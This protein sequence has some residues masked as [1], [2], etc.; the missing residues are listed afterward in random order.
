MLSAQRRRICCSLPSSATVDNSSRPR[1]FVLRGLLLC[2]FPS[3][4]C[5]SGVH[6]SSG[7]PC[8]ERR[9][10]RAES[11]RYD[12]GA[13]E[14]GLCPEDSEGGGSVGVGGCPASVNYG[15]TCSGRGLISGDYIHKLPKGFDR[16]GQ[17]PP[18]RGPDCPTH[19]GLDRISQHT[20]IHTSQEILQPRF[21]SLPWV[22]LSTLIQKNGQRH[23]GRK[24][25]MFL[26]QRLPL[27][28]N[29]IYLRAV[30]S[31]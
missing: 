4:G 6:H 26:G 8:G 20:H 22:S 19:G 25:H 7:P 30:L 9:A 13:G 27:H 11:F 10:R 12:G 23:W 16:S 5:W 17:T 14:G 28:E 29:A 18:V 2:N 21:P 3:I 31:E 1:G 15:S 24:L